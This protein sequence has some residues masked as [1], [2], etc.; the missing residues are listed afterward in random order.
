MPRFFEYIFATPSNHRVHHGSQEKYIN[1]NYGATFIFWDR[2]FGTYQKE[3]EQVIYGI[4]T[5]IENK[6]NPFHVNFHEYADMIQDVKTA[7]GWRKKW[8]YIFGNPLKIAQL[9]KEKLQKSNPV[10]YKKAV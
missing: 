9:K 6:G 1:K 8:F 3:E 7:K 10:V 4:T 5:S 2:L